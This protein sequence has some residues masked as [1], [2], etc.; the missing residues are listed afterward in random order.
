MT[1][2]LNGAGFTA[3]IQANRARFSGGALAVVDDPAYGGITGEALRTGR[4]ASLNKPTS[5]PTQPLRMRCGPQGWT[6]H[7]TLRSTCRCSTA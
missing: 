1:V 5:Q 6:S 2:L 7:P 3:Y 4:S